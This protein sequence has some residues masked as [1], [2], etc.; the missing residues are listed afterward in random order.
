MIL[1]LFKSEPTLRELIPEGFVDIHS[2][3]LPGIDDGAKNIKE[4]LE[5]I[6]EIRKMGFVKVICTPHTYEGVHNNTYKSIE[7]SFNTLNN[8]NNEKIKFN[9]A[10]EY[11]LDNSIIVKAK[12]KSLLC[13]K[14][15]YVLVEMSYISSPINLYEIIFELQTNGYI[16]V[17]AHPERYRFLYVKNYNEFNKLKKVGCMFQINLLSLT[18]YYGKDI[19]DACNYLINNDFCDYFGSDIHNLR[20]IKKFN[21]KVITK[22]ITKIKEI[23]N[24]TILKFI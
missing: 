12:N 4:S 7:Q 9:F 10:S 8:R 13:L 11:M 3:I 21:E 19:V 24:S 2:H 1:N 18:G 6:S 16:P 20:H 14:H 22:N 17:L 15:N 23:I 5:L